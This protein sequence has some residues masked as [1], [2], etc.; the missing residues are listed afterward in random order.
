MK[1]SK[2][3]IAQNFTT[4]D[5]LINIPLFRIAYAN[6]SDDTYAAITDICSF[7]ND[8]LSRDCIITNYMVNDNVYI[9]FN[10]LKCVNTYSDDI[11]DDTPDYSLTFDVQD[12][13]AT[14][15]S[16]S[17]S[18]DE[19]ESLY[20][21]DTMKDL[22]KNIDQIAGDDIDLIAY[23]AASSKIIDMDKFADALKDVQADTTDP[24]LSTNIMAALECITN[25]PKVSNYTLL[26]STKMQAEA[27]KI[28]RAV[29]QEAK[30]GTKNPMGKIKN[31]VSLDAVKDSVPKGSK[32]KVSVTTNLGLASQMLKKKAMSM[33]TKEKEVSR[34]VDINLC[35][36][37]KNIEKAL[38]TDRREAIIKGSIIPSFSKMIKAGMV[39]GGMYLINPVV[40]AIGVIGALAVS[41]ALTERERQTL[42]DEID[43]EL[44]A[45]EKEIST[46]ES[47]NRMKDYRQLLTYQRKLQREKQRIKYRLKLSGKDNIPDVAKEDD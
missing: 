33:S 25:M 32:K 12:E 11:D 37:K 30:A 40:A 34:N 22:F 29:I 20:P 21:I 18:V 6:Q 41:K 39:A 8:Y 42:L 14:L 2:E 36:L 38:T 31:S 27:I 13:M 46:A 9:I 17:E 43:I 24:I 1:A 44:K 4:P 15:L 7:V 26:E 5:G 35:M 3:D 10:Y 23:M 19:I 28:L 47:N 45:V 16:L